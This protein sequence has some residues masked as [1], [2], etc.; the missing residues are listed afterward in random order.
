MRKAGKPA[1]RM[2]NEHAL[3]KTWI[4]KIFGSDV[5]EI[6]LLLRI[7]FIALRPV[8]ASGA[9]VVALLTFRKAA[10]SWMP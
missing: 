8:E 6:I 1:V 9:S 10:T 7:R 2:Q 5:S 3:D 4:L